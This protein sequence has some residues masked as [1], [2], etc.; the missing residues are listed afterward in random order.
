LPEC[1]NM[2]VEEHVSP[3]TPNFCN[4]KGGTAVP[5]TVALDGRTS[6]EATPKH[7]D[8]LKQ[9]STRSYGRV[10]TVKKEF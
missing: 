8:P 4:E 3:A 5:A 10:E 7:R 2:G 1:I 6:P 9:Q